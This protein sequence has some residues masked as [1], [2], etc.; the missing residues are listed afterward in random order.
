MEIL[1]LEIKAKHVR[2]Q[3]V[4]CISQI[5]HGAWLQIGRGGRRRFARD[6]GSLSVHLHLPAK[7]PFRRDTARL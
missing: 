6:F 1:C 2:E 5:A 3:S 7:R 4:E